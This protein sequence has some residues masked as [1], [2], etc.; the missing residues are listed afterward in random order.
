MKAGELIKA[1]QNVDAN[2]LVVMSSDGEGNAFSPVA[3][4]DR[5]M[6]VAESTWSG[7]LVY[8]DEEED[9]EEAYEIE[10][11]FEE[12]VVIWPVN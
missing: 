7:Y 12:V 10:D 2:M 4:I 3:D 8:D 1:L 9:D 6:Y 5:A 11:E